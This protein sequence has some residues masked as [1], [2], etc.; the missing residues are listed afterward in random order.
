MTLVVVGDALLDRDVRG[1][2]GRL[3]PEA[4][5]PVLDAAGE[6]TRPGGAAL[7]A[8]L[9]ARDG[10]EV[11]L[12]TA[13]GGDPAAGELRALLARAGVA[14]VD[15]GLAGRTSEKVRLLADDRL[16]LRLDRA[17]PGGAPVGDLTAE[18][19][20][21][22]GSAG[23]VLVSDYGCGVCSAPG[24]R[25]A[26]EEAAM[27]V[28]VV[29]DPHPRGPEPVRG[30][31]LAT[32]NAGE[33][34]LRVPGVTG[35]GAGAHALRART[36]LERWDAD[37][38]AVT[39]GPRG[40]L[41]VERAGSPFVAPA[42]DVRGG[43]PCGAG[44]RFAV[45][46]AV[47]AAA[48][49][50]TAE[51]VEAAVRSASSFVAAGGAGAIAIGDDEPV[52]AGRVVEER[53][54]AVRARDGTVVATGGCFDLLH[55][56]HVTLLEAARRLGDCLVV[57][58]NSDESVRR[59]KGPD[60]PLVPEEDRIAVLEALSAVDAVVVFDE[61]TPERALERLRPDLWVKGG[62]Y[63]L[64]DLPEAAAV[65]RWGGQAVV[66]PYVPGRSTTR[67]IE[68]AQLRA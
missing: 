15:L 45:T 59:L 66:L 64:A 42:P 9:A 53:L 23:G 2:V 52:P 63:T 68:E 41:L 28:P 21:A 43:D 6:V 26:L 57:L 47:I 55:A 46:A 54:A 1:T 20:D 32:P 30:V 13:L 31:R 60:R 50:L 62:D 18:A 25:E 5:A 4:P 16:L 29:W 44:D 58:V 39:L 38:V 14:V 40:A 61:D 19:C 49:A 10:E 36:L 51:A 11:V 22:L 12:V 3:A 33:A 27:R 34:A 24:V 65:E 48:G 17:E 37:A 67:L 8:A 35:D 7:A 56:G